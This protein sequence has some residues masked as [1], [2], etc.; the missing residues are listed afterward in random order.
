MRLLQLDPDGSEETA[1]DF[2]PIITVVS[3]LGPAG[4]QLILDAVAA[5]PR[6]ADPGCGG[7]V[8]AHGV[9]LDL[10]VETLQMLDLSSDLDVLLRRSDIASDVIAAAA[11]Q[12]EVTDV[13]TVEQF[14][15]A[16]PAGVHPELDAVRYGQLDAREAVAVLRDAAERAQLAVREASGRRERAALVLDEAQRALENAGEEAQNLEVAARDVAARRTELELQVEA[17]G[18][19]LAQIDRSL[20]ELSAIDT[21]PIQVLLDALR[22]PEPEEYV[23]SDRA[24][25]LA[26]EFLRLQT[27]VGELL[28]GLEEEGRGPAAAEQRLEEARAELTAA[29]KA[30]AKPDLSPED[31]VELEAAHDAVLAAE[32]RGSGAF[33]RR[34]Q[35]KL[36]ELRAEEQAVLDR[37]GF[38]TWS[39]YVMGAGLLAIDPFAQERLERARF[40]LEAA[41]AEWAQ[42][43][44]V[45]EADPEHRALLDQLE[46]VYLE[47]FDLLGGDEPDDLEQALR[48]LEVPK[49]EVTTQELVDAMDY[50]LGLVGL[51]LG[52][53]PGVD[54]AIV[55]AE[56]FIEETAGIT[57]RVEELRSERVDIE[58]RKA[59][60]ELELS[61]LPELGADVDGETAIDLMSARHEARPWSDDGPSDDDIVAL[62][63]ELAMTA[64]EEQDAIDLLEARE[65][66][67]DT[68]TRVEAVAT[69]KLMRVA[70]ELLEQ[71]PSLHQSGDTA[72]E[73]PPDGETA[74]AGQELTESY[75]LS[76]LAAHRNISFA[77]SVPLVLDDA[78]ADLDADQVR[79]LLGRL[80]RMADTV[81]IIYLTDDETVIGWALAAGFNRAAVVDAPEPFTL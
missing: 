67:V 15:T 7:L 81:Q 34:N 65:A 17:L 68:A 30:L 55:V 8:E 22:D 76:R 5:L 2:H 72:V 78:L 69:G 31:I 43:S 74:D 36:D 52:E 59:E 48:D 21:R 51:D 25:E 14:L 58:R 75:V 20:D 42:I 23:P 38:P 41:E 77:G 27:A 61:A 64:E 40:A 79:N 57:A 54:R 80:E 70:A 44:A 45:L 63:Q 32:K 73:M 12:A 47:A 29:E 33:S 26:D 19:E 71:S 53:N 39:A 18:A 13:P 56:A 10:G 60:A 28:D 37:V 35:K 6:G 16:T 46:A 50:Q 24:E 9:I 11:P 3:Q 49:G 1:L 66:L 62:E 4:R